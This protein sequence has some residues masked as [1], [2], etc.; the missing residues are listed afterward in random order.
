MRFAHAIGL[1]AGAA[2]LLPVA[3][4]SAQS[5]PN[6][7]IRAEQEAGYLP[8]CRGYELVSPP[9]KNGEEV[10]VPESYAGQVPYDAA[11][12]G[13]AVSFITLGGLPGSLSGGLYGEYL[14]HREASQSSWQT[15]PLNP[16]SRFSPSYT[17]EGSTGYF[18]AFAPDLS[19]GVEQT[20]L[21]QARRGEPETPELAPGES[22]EERVSNLYVHS[23]EGKD[24]SYTL[25]TN[26]RPDNAGERQTDVVDG[27]STDCSHVIFESGYRFLGAPTG[28]LYEWSETEAGK[29]E[30][31]VASILPDG[32]PA[33]GAGEESAVVP[34][35]GGERGSNLNELSSDGSRV[36]F[37]AKANA[38]TDA[39]SEEVFLREDGK[40]IEVSASQTKVPKQD[41]RAKFQAASTGVQPTSASGERVFFTANY[42]LTEHSSSGGKAVVNC[43]ASGNGCDLYRYE[44]ATEK[45]T[46]LSADTEAATGDTEGASVQSVLGI[47]ADGSVVYFSAAGQLVAGQGNSEATNVANA[48][49][50]VYAERVSGAGA[51]TLSYVASIDKAEA[52]TGGSQ[53]ES[54]DA[55]AGPLGLHYTVSRVSANGEYLL[56]ATKHKV[57]EYN[58]EEYENLD[59]SLNKPDFE[60]YEYALQSGSSVCVTCNP[61]RAVRPIAAA[62]PPQGPSGGYQVNHLGYLTR[63][64]GD[65]GS[66][67]FN[68]FDRLLSQAKNETVNVY[69]W[70]PNGVQSLAGA[71]CEGAA[72]CL[73]LLD[74]GTD[75]H[76]SYFADASVSGDDVYLTTQQAL[77]SQD[78]DGLRDLYDVRAGGG[79]PA[80][81]AK[82]RCAEEECQG[83]GAA[84]QTAP[85][86]YA[87]ESGAAGNLSPAAPAPGSGSKGVA[88]FSAHSLSVKRKVRGTK[89]TVAIAAPAA[90][91]IAIAGTGLHG[92]ARTVPK[93]GVYRLSVALTAKERRVLAHRRHVRLRLRVSFTPKGGHAAAVA[94]YVTFLR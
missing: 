69:E 8:A 47:S 90:G 58:G 20:E 74:S 52:G 32:T 57:R 59:Q 13:N 76:A 9:L 46:D 66:V 54:L 44:V 80:P 5:C 91:R 77:V 26:V 4:A 56:F 51:G 93:A 6:E 7:A 68:S 75:S 11:A 34:A 23:G 22:A 21:P 35:D 15:F 62:G 28:S 67:F 24:G 14:A 94:A 49:A 86:G 27:V 50:N 87:S 1:L 88:A 61:D 25:L 63:T 30:L 84:G 17:G 60:S 42:G 33:K 89:V 70:R 53:L 2:L 16:E 82:T 79:F 3:G 45:L 65:T 18:E 81:Q 72:G 10:Q 12:G 73:G 85:S 71:H 40:T 55:I 39:G 31:R 19:C 78:Q 83:R 43:E 41:T 37:T 92:V 48:E 29:G 64:L 38:G 36:F